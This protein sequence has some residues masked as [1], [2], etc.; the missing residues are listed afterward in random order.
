M[1]QESQDRRQAAAV[2]LCDDP[3]EAVEQGA[4]MGP[5]L[6]EMSGFGACL[7]PRQDSLAMDGNRYMEVSFFHKT[8]FTARKS[9][10]HVQKKAKKK[11]CAP[12]LPAP[13]I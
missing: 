6:V 11:K 7:D 10:F 4:D 2:H 9:S 1:I 12:V 13:F 5:V 3:A 8:S